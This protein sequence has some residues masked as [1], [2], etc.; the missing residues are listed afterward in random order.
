MVHFIVATVYVS[1][2]GHLLR[3][4]CFDFHTFNRQNPCTLPTQSSHFLFTVTSAAT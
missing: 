3:L 4:S 2:K 1:E